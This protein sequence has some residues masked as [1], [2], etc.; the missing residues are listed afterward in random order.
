MLSQETKVGFFVLAGLAAL[1]VVTVLLGDIHL[2]RR[3]RIKII[4]T[5][6]SG[7]PE[8]AQVRR[9]G[10][11]VGKVIDIKLV[12]DKAQ[13]TASIRK[14]ARIHKD[15]QARI[16]S[17]G[18]VGTKYLEITSGSE[19]EPLIEDGDTITGI[20]PV[21][22]D[23]AVE[24]VLVGVV[25]I[26]DKLK[27]MGKEEELGRSL[28]RILDN[29]GDVARKLNRALGM[30]GEELKGTIENLQQLSANVRELTD[31]LDKESITNSL[32]KLDT[33]LNGIAQIMENL[34]RGQG[35]MG[36]L[37]T[38]EKMAEQVEQ[39]VEN[40]E[41][42]SERAKE[43]LQTTSG[44]GTA[45][46]YRLNYNLNEEKVRSDFGLH[47]LPSSKG[48]YYFSINNIGEDSN[49]TDSGDQRVNSIS[50]KVGKNFGLFSLY[51]GIIR[52]TGGF[53]GI[54]WPIK[55]RIE[56]GAEVF[57][58]SRKRAWLNTGAKL[59]LSDWCYFGINGEDILNQG[60]VNSS[61][62]IVLR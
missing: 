44:L 16:V 9:A 20:E 38:D 57:R 23:V 48:F 28:K 27:E 3:Y 24:K 58:L 60:T 31:S 39:M 4:F 14:D 29:I 46:E 8:K 25:E 45:W 30:E 17:F 1:A 49:G 6:V 12:D 7:L 47:L 59:R 10:V 22:I 62:G 53:G 55:E 33:T 50:V 43:I 21:S 2:E 37:L 35:V 15:A 40:L 51:G 34:N 18:I 36:R 26:T 41:E 11:V 56:I 61:I 5:D 52:S 54:F 19:K 32:E 42:S 13:V